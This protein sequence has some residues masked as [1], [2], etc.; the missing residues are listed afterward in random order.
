MSVRFRGAILF[1]FDG[2]LAPNL[3]LPDMRRRVIG[4]TRTYG[5]DDAVW[6]GCYI[7]EIIEASR[8]H[9]AGRDTELAREYH[10]RAHDLITRFELDAAARTQVFPWARDL[11]AAMRASDLGTAIVT[12]NCEAAVQATF[13]D[14]MTHVDCLLTRDNVVHLKPDPRHFE[15]A[16]HSLGVSPPRC[17]VVSDGAMDMRTGRELGLCCIGVLGGSSDADTLRSAG[18]ELVLENAARLGSVVDRL[19]EPITR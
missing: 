4:L 3:D 11:L 13:P 2:T 16:M 9:L 18:A 12:R 17:M 14:V 8:C 15:S 5:V 7:V 19:V 10:T 1:D 6:Q